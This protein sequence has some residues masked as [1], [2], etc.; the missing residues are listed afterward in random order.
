M[1]FCFPNG[2]DSSVDQVSV[3]SLLVNQITFF[4]AGVVSPF[5][6]RLRR[7]VMAWM[8]CG[9]MSPPVSAR[10]IRWPTRPSLTIYGKVAWLTICFIL[11]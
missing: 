7:S 8:V 3:L 1:K 11:V 2:E 9:K 5:T 10:A 4:K 6:R